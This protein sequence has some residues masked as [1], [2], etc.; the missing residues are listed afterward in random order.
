MG[1]LDNYEK[2]PTVYRENNGEMDFA[3]L[4]KFSPKVYESFR[5]N[6]DR[7][8]ANKITEFAKRKPNSIVLTKNWVE[9]TPYIYITCND[10]V[11]LDKISFNTLCSISQV[12]GS[13]NLHISSGTPLAHWES[14]RIDEINAC[15]EHKRAEDM[16]TIKRLMDNTELDINDLFPMFDSARK[17]SRHDDLVDEYYRVLK[18]YKFF[19]EETEGKETVSALLVIASIMDE[20]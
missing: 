9:Y 6:V 10:K 19:L 1:N 12:V 18:R 2:V 4:R 5:V 3:E 14:E 13:E 8:T 17:Q 11:I 7:D 20:M 16:V 15:H